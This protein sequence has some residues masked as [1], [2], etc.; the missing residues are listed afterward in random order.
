MQPSFSADS[1]SALLDLGRYP[2]PPHYREIFGFACIT[3]AL[4]P[5]GEYVFIDPHR[6]G[7]AVLVDSDTLSQLSRW[8]SFHSTLGQ[9]GS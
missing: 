1:S 8:R 7:R 2:C 4:T 5:T 9:T 6:S 3:L